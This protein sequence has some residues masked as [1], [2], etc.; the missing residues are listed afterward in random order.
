[1]CD[2]TFHT[3]LDTKR[4][5]SHEPVLIS[6]IQNAMLHYVCALSIVMAHNDYLNYS[7]D[8]TTNSWRK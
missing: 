1:M 4:V 6:I 2:D 7:T 3:K 8:N 5:S